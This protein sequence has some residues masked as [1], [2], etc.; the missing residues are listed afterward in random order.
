M[1]TFRAGRKRGGLRSECV[2]VSG[3]WH[4]V[5]LRRRVGQKSHRVVVRFMRA[6]G[7]VVGGCA[8]RGWLGVTKGGGVSGSG[9][10]GGGGG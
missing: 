9:K 6:L 8:G 2:C 4:G 5:V 7:G 3:V 10:G 1:A